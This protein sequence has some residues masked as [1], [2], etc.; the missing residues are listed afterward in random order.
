MS[1][2]VFQQRILP[3][4]DK[5]YRLALRL[6]QNVQEAEDVVQET[7]MRIWAKREEWD[8]WQNLEAY[9]MISARNSCLDKLRKQ[10]MRPVREEKAWD[11]GSTDKDPQEKMEAKQAVIQIRKCM[12]Q[13]PAHQQLVIQ[14]R[15]I[16]GF[17]YNEI[18]DVLDM[19]LDQVKVNLFRARNAIKRSIIKSTST[20]QEK[21]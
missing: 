5:L 13:L 20:W 11:I 8:G 17:S 4:K 16:E 19:S 15:E 3:M 21:E 10:K 7:M 1:L 2:Q 14:L 18:A 9:C 12:E 6:L